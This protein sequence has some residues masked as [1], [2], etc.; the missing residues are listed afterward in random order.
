MNLLRQGG[1]GGQSRQFHIKSIFDFD[2]Q[3]LVYDRY[4]LGGSTLGPEKIGICGEKLLKLMHAQTS[5]KH[6]KSAQRHQPSQ[7]TPYLDLRG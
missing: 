7:V 6:M 3:H 5:F 1:G 4:H 2:R